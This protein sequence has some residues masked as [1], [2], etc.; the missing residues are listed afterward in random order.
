M[1]TITFFEKTLLLVVVI[2]APPILITVTV[3]ILIS[4]L[5]TLFQIQD[6]TLPFAMKLITMT[7]TLAA[8]GAW[9]GGEVIN[10]T[11]AA[12]EYIPYI[13]K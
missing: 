1:E 4:L 9:M 13:G 7:L 3:G 11:K 2:S 10:L 5:Q 6:Q 8:V 12:F